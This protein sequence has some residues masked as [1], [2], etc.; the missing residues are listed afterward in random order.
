LSGRRDRRAASPLD[1]LDD[2][3][4]QALR[5]ERRRN[6]RRGA[7]IGF[8]G[9]SAFLGI[10]LVFGAV[11]ARPLWR[12]QI[13]FLLLSWCVVGALYVASVRSHRFAELAGLAIP[14]VYMPI[15]VVA[16]WGIIQNVPAQRDGPATYALAVLLW[17]IVAA[18]LAL[19]GRQ[20]WLAAGVATVLAVALQIL[21]EAPIEVLGLCVV[22]TVLVAATCAYAS[23]RTVA[24]VRD[25]TEEHQRRE[26]LARYFSPQVAAVLAGRR[27]P[28]PVGDS[29]EVTILFGDLREFSA[30]S[31]GMSAPAVVALL[32]EWHEQMVEAVFEH[33]GTLDKFLGDGLM[34]YFGAPVVQTDHAE[35][36]IRCALAMQ[37]RLAGLNQRRAARGERPLWMG[38]GL[39]TGV[40]VLG[41]VGA[42]RRREYTA[43]GSAV[44][45]AARIER[46]TR[47][48]GAPVLVSEE[49]HHRAPSIACTRVGRV[50]VRGRSDPLECWAPNAE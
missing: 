21:V 43:I 29:H 48:L 37:V 17:L 15:V 2:P 35:R 47:E 39:H 36:A 50:Q 19:D 3:L 10:Y 44:N 23:G 42:S 26:R 49:T 11:F 45:V 5:A 46:L 28:S 20:L 32:N 7:L 12:G 18:A 27:D 13:P 4:A 33:G 30:L 14:F 40:V 31:E 34:A 22:A 1:P 41:D 6:G 25:V 16:V 38:I 9:I 24:L 8:V